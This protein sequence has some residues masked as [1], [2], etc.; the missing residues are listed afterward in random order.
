MNAN[1]Q[2]LLTQ[3]NASQAVSLPEFIIVREQDI[4]YYN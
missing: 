2:T 4:I 3:L 1:L